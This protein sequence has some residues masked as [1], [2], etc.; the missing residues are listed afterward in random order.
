MNYANDTQALEDIKNGLDIHSEV[1][2]YIWPHLYKP[3]TIVKGEHRVAAKTVVFGL[4][5]GRGIKS[6]T[7]DPSFR[8]TESEALRIIKWFFNKYPKA[9]EW[10]ENQ[11]KLVKRDKQVR[12][13]FGRVRRLPEI[14]SKEE[15]VRSEILRQCINVPIQSMASDITSISTIRVHNLLKNNNMK[16]KLFFTIHDSVKYNVPIEELDKAIELI[17]IGL[18]TPIKGVNFPLVTEFEIGRNW[19]EMIELEDFNKERNKYLKEW[20]LI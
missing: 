16:T 6:L 9:N 5:F 20:K 4:I 18:G 2:C 17:N 1:A 14:D 19:G 3:G 15:Q 12:N 13:F 8:L 10:I 7:T 11:K